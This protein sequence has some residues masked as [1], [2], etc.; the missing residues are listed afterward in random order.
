MD[1]PIISPR[2]LDNPNK[3]YNWLLG[4][5]LITIVSLVG[6]WASNTSSA[7]SSHAQRLDSIDKNVAIQQTQYEDL[8][9]RMIDLD[10]KVS[11]VLE[12]EKEKR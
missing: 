1:I 11:R 4:L 6:A 9:D 2:D 3:V 8:R 7:L 5:A 12:I 10:K